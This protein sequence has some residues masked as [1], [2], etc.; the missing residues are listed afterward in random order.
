MTF[1][2]LW[3]LG[4]VTKV[5]DLA[6][7][8]WRSCVGTFLAFDGSSQTEPFPRPATGPLS[9]NSPKLL[10]RLPGRLLPAVSAAVPQAPPSAPRVSPAASAA[11]AGNSSPGALYSIAGGGGGGGI[12]TLEACI[13]HAK[14]I[15]YSHDV[16]SR[17]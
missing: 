12:A 2:N 6:S 4:Q 1:F 5:D 11:A 10:R 8:L 17:H 3:A 7:I 13:R 14:E 15:N 16:W 9:W